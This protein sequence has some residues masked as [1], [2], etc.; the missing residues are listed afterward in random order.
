MKQYAYITRPVE[1]LEGTLSTLTLFADDRDRSHLGW[2]FVSEIDID[3]S[4]LD[5]AAIRAA[6]VSSIDQEIDAA[7]R[8]YLADL[9]EMQER[10]SRLLSIEH[11]P[12][13]HDPEG[14]VLLDGLS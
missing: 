11:Q 14:D 7:K 4:S 8:V 1:Y 3:L 13:C 5:D 10:K 9:E 12:D 6:A 2:I